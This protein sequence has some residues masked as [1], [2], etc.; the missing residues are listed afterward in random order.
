VA[1]PSRTPAP[2]SAR[3]RESHAQAQFSGALRDGVRHDAVKADAGKQQ[4]QAS[5]QLD[6]SYGNELL[7]RRPINVFLQR[8]HFV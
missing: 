1:E 3:P 5:E 7:G 6:Q 2:A 4:R 8:D